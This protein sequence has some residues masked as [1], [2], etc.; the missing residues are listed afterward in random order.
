MKNLILTGLMFLFSIPV[1]TQVTDT[2]R[3]NEI[4]IGR[5]FIADSTVAAT[6]YVFPENIYD[7]A[8]DD[9]AKMATFQLRGTKTRGGGDELNDN[10]NVFRYDLRDNRIKWNRE[11]NFNKAYLDCYDTLLIETNNYQSSSLNNDTG[12]NGWKTKN[13]IEY[14]SL[15]T[16]IGVGYK[17]TSLSG[18]TNTFEGI[19]LKTGKSLWQRKIK[20]NYNPIDISPLNDSVL[21]VWADGLHSVNLRTGTGW[22]Y[23]TQTAGKDYSG[24][25]VSSIFN[26][27]IS[28]LLNTE[29]DEGV[30]NTDYDLTSGIMSNL[31]IDSTGIY[32]A[33]KKSIARL[34][35]NGNVIW[36]TILPKG[37]AS[38]SNLFF[39]GNKLCM[40]NAGLAS[41]NS[42]VVSFGKPFIAAFDKDTGK[43][44]FLNSIVYK[45]EQINDN[46]MRQDTI[47]LLS[48][49]RIFKYALK[50]GTELWEQNFKTDSVG[51]IVRFA[52]AGMFL[53][54]D[55]VGFYPLVSDSTHLYVSTNRG[56]VLVLNNQ[57]E[58]LDSIPDSDIFYSFLETNGCKFMEDGVSCF[59]IDKKN[60][61]IAELD[62]RSNAVLRG[63]KLLEVQEKTL[64]KIDIR[65]F[66]K[67]E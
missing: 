41:Y 5:N 60:K 3:V 57:M 39:N 4:V 49:K 66:I 52:D 46:L 48:K 14:V 59:V 56:Q 58:L 62:I 40:V 47:Y 34:D 26:I 32:L 44:E 43:K 37:Q 45:K 8:V 29:S 53:K 16:G 18:F 31:L 1:F 27:G 38:K 7:W 15:K 10:G 63:T 30:I 23:D 19:D 33:D 35:Y 21:I 11:I 6:E 13:T 36:K 54:S 24:A 42:D 55:S 17:Y 61:P 50:N 25:I 28:L 51:E 9:S 65:Q 67:K 64:V 2:V 12:E 20:R 22:D